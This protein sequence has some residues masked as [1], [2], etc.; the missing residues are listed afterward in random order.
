MTSTRTP[1]VIVT[2]LEARH[3]ARAGRELLARPG[4]VV[5]HHDIGRLGEGVVLRT[6]R[7]HTDGGIEEDLTAVELAHGC[8]S[9]TL[10]MDLLPLL[11]ELGGRRDTARVVL[12]LDP[13]L[14]PEHLCWSVENL[15]LDDVPAEPTGTA[16]DRVALAG[17]LAVID[18]A[19]WLDDVTGGEELADR[20]LAATPDD[21]RTL[22]QVGIGQVAFAD[23]VLLAGEPVDAW[24]A[25]R[26]DAVLDRLVAEVP[27]VAASTGAEDALGLVGPGSRNGRPSSPHDP[28]FPGRPPIGEDVGVGVIRFAAKR[29]FH[30]ERLH[31]ALD[32]LLEGVVVSRGRVWL[33]SQHDR[34]LWMESAGQGLRM[35]DAGPWL[36]T[37]PDDS[38]EWAGIDPERQVAA[39]LCWDPLHGDRRIEVAVLSHR[40]PGAAV[41]AALDAAL[42][43]D[44]EL[45]SGPAAWRDLP[46]PFGSWHED[47]CEATPA[48]DDRASTTERED[49]A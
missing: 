45:A 41:I 23:A 37:L 13:A 43:T 9:C 34:A 3:C 42:L 5:V 25:A 28:L 32:V 39:A 16:G 6:V 1:L 20:G 33:A 29:P 19:T 40:Q 26:L 48:P 18:P 11:R 27:R 44:E 30:P 49:R 47:P 24:S 15:V 36:A 14:E 8:L 4:T 35:G 12:Q 38:P 31:D 46:D 10:R 7:R 2:G 21:D 17:V 22:A